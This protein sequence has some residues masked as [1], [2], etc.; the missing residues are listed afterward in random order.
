MEILIPMGMII[1]KTS[2]PLPELK[3]HAY[4]SVCKEWL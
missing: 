1:Y 4:K 2:V 3:N